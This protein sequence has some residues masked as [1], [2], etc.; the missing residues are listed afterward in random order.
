MWC[1]IKIELKRVL[2]SKLLYISL[3]IGLVFAFG[4]FAYRC[5][6]VTEKLDPSMVSVQG[7]PMSVFNSWM[8]LRMGIDAMATTYIYICMLIASM[9]YCGVL[10]SDMQSHYINQYYVR[11]SKVKILM[12]RFI[13]TFISGGILVV[14]PL[15]VNL[16]AT[17]TVV[18]ALNP[19]YNGLFVLDGSCFFADIF[20]NAPML[21]VFLYIFMFFLYGGAFCVISLVTSYIFDNSFLVILSPFVAYYGLGIVSSLCF[22]IL[23]TNKFD[24]VYLLSPTTQLDA[25]GALIMF[26]EPVIIT[27]ICLIAFLSKGERDEAL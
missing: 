9:A 6:L 3:L 5:L 13:V 2:K 16:I 14:I 15:I 4:S 18:P 21:Y 10:S 19:V 17:M 11:I 27:A 26:I 1:L 25:T 24:P 23:G 20:F 12:S 7:Y 8:G 22:R